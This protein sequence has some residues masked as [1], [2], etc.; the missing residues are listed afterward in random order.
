MSSGIGVPTAGIAQRRS[1]AMQHCCSWL[2][3]III[4]KSL[5]FYHRRLPA[6]HFGTVRVGEVCNFAKPLLYGASLK[7]V[8]FI[9][10][11]RRLP[12]SPEF[13]ATPRFTHPEWI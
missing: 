6:G 4:C 1:A 13:A 11:I 8:E 5:S 9:P 2:L 7:A 12:Q 3:I 10:L